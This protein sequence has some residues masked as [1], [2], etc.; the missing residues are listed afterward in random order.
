MKVNPD[1]SIVRLK[2]RLDAK[3]YAQ[4]HGVNYSDTFSLV[5]KMTSVLLFISLAATYNW[6]IHQLDIMNIFLH[7]NLQKVYMEQPL[8]FVAQEEI[9]RVYCLRKPLYGLKQSPCAWFGKFKQAVEE[10][11][12]Q[13][14]KSDH[15][16]FYRNSRS[17][18]ILFVVY[19]DDIVITKSLKVFYL[20][21]P[22]FR[23]N[24]IQKTC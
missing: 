8:G 20:L 1:G 13:K 22:F 24:F 19:V 7:S 10:F 5:A 12:M 11:G 2:A 6:D 4:T 16:V 3:G 15:S 18:I 17:G 14:S 23:A 9:G 21:S